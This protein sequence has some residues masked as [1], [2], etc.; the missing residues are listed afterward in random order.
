MGCAL[1]VVVVVVVVV[2]LG[3]ECVVVVGELGVGVVAC[4]L[5]VVVTNVVVEGS[6]E[7]DAHPANTKTQTTSQ[8]NRATPRTNR[9]FRR[10]F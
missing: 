5:G 6:T 7:G 1:G 10:L 3:G 8:P 4:E 2:A 9:L